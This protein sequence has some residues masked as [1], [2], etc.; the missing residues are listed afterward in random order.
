MGKA[1]DQANLLT[2][3]QLQQKEELEDQKRDFIK[4]MHSS[5]FNM[6]LMASAT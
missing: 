2:K 5:I 4:D 6:I 1:A 3:E